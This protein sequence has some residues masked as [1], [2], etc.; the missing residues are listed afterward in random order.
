MTNMAGPAWR[1]ASTTGPSGRS[2]PTSATRVASNRRTRLRSP[3]VSWPMGE[4]LPVV[5]V[6]DDPHIADLVSLYLDQSG[7]R[8]YRADNGHDGLRIIDERQPKLVIRR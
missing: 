1:T 6:E 5:L 2:I 4:P 7:F 3:A 8:V